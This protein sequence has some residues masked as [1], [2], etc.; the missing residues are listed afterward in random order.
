[1]KGAGK[2]LLLI[3]P[4]FRRLYHPDASL[5]RLPLSLG[6]LAG[7]VR[8]TRP[9]WEVRIF[10]ADFSPRDRPLDCTYLAGAG[11][12]SFLHTLSDCQAPIWKEI[13]HTI[14]KFRPSVVG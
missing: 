12:E 10:N 1:M 6:Y 13:G 2:R 11:Y 7:A 14:S 5:N 8:S 4:P 3:E 9:D